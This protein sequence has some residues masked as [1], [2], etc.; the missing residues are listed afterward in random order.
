MALP[1]GTRLDSR[2]TIESVIG[3]GG[4]GITYIAHHDSLGR[5]FAIKEHFPRQ[6]AY[7]DGA[8]WDV[9]PT[10]RA[11]F[12]W[13]LDRFLQEGR[14]LATCKH[15]NVVDVTDV[16]EGNSTAYMV[17]VYEPGH[18]LKSWL[19]DLG[20]TPTQVEIDGLLAPLLDALAFVHAN[21]LLHRDI[22]PDNIMVRSDGTPC[23]IDFGAARQAIAQRSQVVSAIVKSGYS[24]PEQ[25][26]T[27]G[28]A[29]GP[30]SD[31]YALAATLY[32]AVTGRVPPEATARTVGLE[33]PPVA[34]AL[35]AHMRDT[36]RPGFLAAIDHALSLRPVDRP[37]SVEAWRAG[38]LATGKLSTR[39]IV[40]PA[41]KPTAALTRAPPPN[42]L[43]ALAIA[44]LAI[45]TV[46]L[47]GGGY[48]AFVHLP[49]E[50]EVAARA[51]TRAKVAADAQR[52]A[53]AEAR[54][55][56]ERNAREAEAK[57]MAEAE[58]RKREEAEARRRADEAAAEAQR[59]AKEEAEQQRE[60]EFRAK[61]ELRR[62]QEDA[63]RQ[64]EARG[65]A[66]I[67]RM[68]VPIDNLFR[69]WNSLDLQLY[70][71]QWAPDGIKVDLKKGTQQTRS[72]L[73][74]DRALLFG[75]LSGA[76][77]K[78]KAGLR[79]FR[80]GVGFF[81]VSYSLTIRYK[82]GHTFS[83]NACERYRVERRGSRWLIV[84]NEDYAP[85]L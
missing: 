25:Y 20:R 76:S 34:D 67:E 14:S 84:L 79:E 24:P 72:A 73:Q 45:G 54:A 77:A 50:R 36:F 16:F 83:E 48:Y 62:A 81:D 46:V 85:C 75:R 53:E 38:L 82:T 63:R 60:A 2:Y 15:P 57:R 10:D 18:S 43:R 29:Q 55:D 9:R 40:A 59:K 47:V 41:G 31:I 68:R 8:S 19:E 37:Q 4:F 1:P 42:H 61:E 28:R 17:L 35:P 56:A 49:A 33:M 26:T 66:E 7:R 12:T 44:L 32:R 6:F 58:A 64:A 27:E 5:I 30:W 39:R 65:A 78:F 13:A 74:V 80:D 23:L 22:A 69:A 3:A 52:E 51:A 21:G 70:M 71:D 11:T